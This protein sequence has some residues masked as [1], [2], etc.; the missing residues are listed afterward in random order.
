M[1]DSPH[2]PNANLPVQHKILRH[3]IAFASL[4][5]LVLVVGG[6][7]LAFERFPTYAN[8]TMVLGLGTTAVV[9]LFVLW[10]VPEWQVEHVS[11][12]EPKDRFDCINAARTTLAQI[13]GGVFLLAGVYA[14][15]QNL[16]MA[17]ESVAVAQK[18]LSVAQEGQITDRFTKAIEQL[19]EPGDQKLAARLG[20]IYALE[21]IANES[22]KDHWPIMEVLTAYVRE[23]ASKQT[24][25]SIE[26]FKLAAD[27]QAILTVLGRRVRKYEDPDQMT[28]DLSQ[29]DIRG[30]FVDEAQLDGT[31]LYGADISHAHLPHAHLAGAH[32][33]GASL[34]G[35]HL[36]HADLR[37]AEL[38]KANF[39]DAFL[40]AVDFSGAY[41]CGA[42]LRYARSLTQ[43]Q[44]DS[45]KGDA[46]TRLP[47]GLH[48]PEAWKGCEI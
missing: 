30:A 38:T 14:T 43:E 12:L 47:S 27:I 32:L 40:L 26:D 29:A 2:V 39:N 19:G 23:N 1:A 33:N 4:V 15:V 5:L 44:L 20:G 31:Y 9:A 21:R 8:W 28:L 46:D 37:N 18:S 34:N 45:A 25:V 41:L 3:G 6:T 42:D 35:T 22:G 36:P 13:V 7:W 10:K 48:M 17:Q 24:Q 16:A 11:G